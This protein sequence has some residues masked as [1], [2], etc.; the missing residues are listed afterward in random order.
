MHSL[1]PGFARQ[2][3]GANAL[4]L[5]YFVWFLNRMLCDVM[6]VVD[7]EYDFLSISHEF[8]AQTVCDLYKNDA[9]VKVI[10]FPYCMRRGYVEER[11]SWK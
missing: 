1:L 5:E 10:R 11:L 7:G 2:F 3:S 4:Q 8:N 9:K 6:P